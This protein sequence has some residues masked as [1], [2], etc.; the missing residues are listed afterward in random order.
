MV[1]IKGDYNQ[2]QIFDI[3]EN[4]QILQS[5]LKGHKKTYQE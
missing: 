4:L 1:T 2:N 3:R 5:F